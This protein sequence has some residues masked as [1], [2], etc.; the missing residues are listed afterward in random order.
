MM[1]QLLSKLKPSPSLDAQKK[2]DTIMKKFTRTLTCILALSTITT[3]AIADEDAELVINGELSV[4]TKAAAPADSAL[5]ELISGWR[6]RTNE[7]QALQMDD[8]DNP[9]FIFIE[10][11]E[12]LYAKVDG[13]EGKSCASCH[14]DVA[15]FE[16]LK[17]TLPRHNASSGKLDTMETLVNNCRTERMGAEPWKWSKG[18]MTAMTSL[19]SLQSR[20]MPVNVKTDGEAAGAYDLGKELYYTRVGQLDMSCANCHEDNYGNMIRADHLSQGQINGFP[21]Y[22]LKNAKM[23]S[24][25]ARFKGCMTN[26]RATPFKEGSEEFRALELYVASRGNGL[27]VESPSVRN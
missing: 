4:A 6:F 23:N 20:G 8:F 3:V 24:I 18:K 11:G 14:E 12:D 26:I 10:Q 15:S 27:S 19:I 21:T 1:V 9:S 7:T 22:R 13:S 25:H 5:D 17:S 2:G 16:G